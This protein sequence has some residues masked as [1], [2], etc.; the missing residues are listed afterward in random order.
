MRNEKGVALVLSMFLMMAMSVVGATLMFLSQTETYSS[1]NYRLM[2]Q[3][4]YGA[5]SGIQ[6]AA[7]YLLNTYVKPKTTGGADPLSNYDTTVSPVRYNNQDVVLSSNPSASNYPIDA[8]KT[9]FSAAASGTLPFGT[10]T[11]AYAPTATLLSMREIDVYGGGKET[12]Q[13]WRIDSV[14]SVVIGR[15]AQV[16]VTAV[17]EAQRGPAQMYAAF[18][19]DDGCGALTFSGSSFTDSYDSSLYSGAGAITAGNGGLLTSGGDVGTNGNLGESGNATINGTLST[20]RVGVGNCSEGNVDALTQSGHATVTGGIVQLP[21][22]VAMPEPPAIDPL[23]PTSPFNGNNETLLN[24]ASVGNVTVSNGTLTLGAVG[25]TSYITVNSVKFTGNATINILGTVI[26]QVAG[27]GESRPI[28]FTGGSTTNLSM[29]PS[30]FQIQYAGTGEI[31]LTGGSTATAMVYAPHAEVELTGNNDF[32]GSIVAGRLAVTGN[33]TIHYDRRL[34]QEF[35][36]ATNPMLSS[37]SWKK[38]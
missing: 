15:T 38:Y 32:Y 35:F 14:G 17:L 34:E 36:T 12:I 26:L 5:E 3:A 11:V 27:V 18:A 30:N 28:E 37:F 22:A 33:A 2:S 8:V 21:Q 20:P 16:E 29:D 4:R 13:T 9:A 25:V 31:K 24:G 19:T 6:V 23:P 10:T 7:N 1:M